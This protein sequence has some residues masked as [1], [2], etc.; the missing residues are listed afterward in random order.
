MSAWV[1]PGTSPKDPHPVLRLRIQFPSFSPDRMKRH[2]APIDFTTSSLRSGLILRKTPADVLEYGWY[3]GGTIL[4]VC[5]AAGCSP[6]L[7]QR[8]S[9]EEYLNLEKKKRVYHHKSR[10]VAAWYSGADLDLT[11]RG[12]I[13]AR[14]ARGEIFGGVA[15]LRI[16]QRTYVYDKVNRVKSLKQNNMPAFVFSSK[17]IYYIVILQIS[18]NLFLNGQNVSDSTSVNTDYCLIITINVKMDDSKNSG[19]ALPPLAPP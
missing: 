13:V 15:S 17:L 5:T 3:C 2:E 1:F 6:L 14:E 8:R 9:Q 18:S 11:A 16:A 12:G 10:P 19:W 4:W 7:H